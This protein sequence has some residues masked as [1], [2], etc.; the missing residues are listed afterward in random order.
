MLFFV[1]QFGTATLL[2]FASPKTVQ[3]WMNIQGVGV[4]FWFE[5]LLITVPVCFHF[6][7]GLKFLIQ[8]RYNLIH[9]FYQG[10]L[11]FV[12]QRVAGVVG[13]CFVIFHVW[14]IFSILWSGAEGLQYL[15]DVLLAHKTVTGVVLYWSAMILMLFYWWN[16]TWNA[17]ID[18]GVTV[19]RFSQK[20]S[21][22]ARVSLFVVMAV[23]CVVMMVAWGVKI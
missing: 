19:S 12:L 4:I 7:Y 8:P 13:L 14:Q 1:L 10:N 11:R 5:V 2:L 18:W 3:T 23:C 6:L 20:V 16:G 22:I 15:R 17:L 21:L 9:Y